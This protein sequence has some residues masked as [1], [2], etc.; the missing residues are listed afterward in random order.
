MSHKAL[1]AAIDAVEKERERMAA[2]TIINILR[3]P[4]QKAELY[5]IAAIEAYEDNLW[6][7]I[8]TIPEDEKWYY[9]YATGE[10]VEVGMPRSFDPN[11]TSGPETY[12]LK[13]DRPFTIARSDD[14][15]VDEYGDQWT[16]DGYLWELKDDT[17][18]EKEGWLRITSWRNTPQPP[19]DKAGEE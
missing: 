9:A 2:R 10:P 8:E 13:R 18:E 5:V 12:L 19:K 11:D 1:K 16:L 17:D 3:T 4:R 7:P 15:Y 14:Y 6:Q